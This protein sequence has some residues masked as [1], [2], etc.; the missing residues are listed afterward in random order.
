MK[1]LRSL[2]LKSNHNSYVISVAVALL[3]ASV[4]LGV[5]YVL[6][7][8]PQEG[9]MTIYLLD[10]QR[11]ATNYPERVVNGVNSTFSVYVDVE[12][13]MGN[14]TECQVLMKVTRN[15]NPTFPVAVNATETFSG[16]L[17]DGEIWENVATVSLDQAGDYL[18]FFEL[19]TPNAQGVFQ[20][21]E[22]CSLSVQVL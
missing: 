6:L 1:T 19:W 14:A 16:T 11:K 2:N 3:I 18:I 15:M 4:L 17:K 7:R 5:Y 22:L 13:H 20:Y 10:S 9:Y 21:K 12:N 8:P